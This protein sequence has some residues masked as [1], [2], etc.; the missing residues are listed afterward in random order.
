MHIAD[1]RVLF[2]DDTDKLRWF[3]LP[4]E[5]LQWLQQPESM[6]TQPA[7]PLPFE[8]LLYPRQ[9][10]SVVPGYQLSNP[11]NFKHCFVDPSQ[12]SRAMGQNTKCNKVNN[13]NTETSSRSR[14]SS[15]WRLRDGKSKLEESRNPRKNSPRNV[16]DVNSDDRTMTTM[17]ASLMAEGLLS[18]LQEI[19][20][21]K[22]GDTET[23]RNVLT[24]CLSAGFLE[25]GPNEKDLKNPDAHFQKTDIL[26]G[27]EASPGRT[28]PSDQ[29]E[30]VTQ[31]NSDNPSV[32][33]NV[34]G[35]RERAGIMS[36]N[37]QI[38]NV[39]DSK[40]SCVNGACFRKRE[41]KSTGTG[42]QVAAPPAG[43]R[44]H[45]PNKKI[46]N[47]SVKV[48]SCDFTPI[49]KFT[50]IKSCKINIDR[51]TV[52]TSRVPLFLEIS[53]KWLFPEKSGKF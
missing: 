2:A 5:A 52:H 6:T 47:A 51:I 8:P 46:F 41:T 23:F 7:A 4:S 26:N 33:E 32:T 43:H 24:K 13:S 18:A 27:Q 49:R 3:L 25:D 11:A 40:L 19:Q 12:H 1:Q 15:P 16:K 22:T 45:P 34:T 53:E 29:S 14:E 31:T 20:S 10:D 28:A 21:G 17:A 9:Q 36:E 48:T 30:S 35:G 39:P 50:S 38:G 37:E 42:S 44:W